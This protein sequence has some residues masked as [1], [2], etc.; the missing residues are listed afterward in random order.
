MESEGKFNYSKF[1]EQV[2][3]LD[4]EKEILNLEHSQLT[5]DLEAIVRSQSAVYRELEAQ[6]LE[7]AE[8][9]RHP[10]WTSFNPRI[11][12]ISGRFG[13]INT[14]VSQ[15]WAEIVNIRTEQDAANKIFYS[16]Q[17]ETKN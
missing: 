8:I 5:E 3:E 6:G 11:K 17:E 15:I 1:D 13:Q 7:D 12:E 2:K 4:R 9:R 16:G 14:R 10:S